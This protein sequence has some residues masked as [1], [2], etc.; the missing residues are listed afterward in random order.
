MIGIAINLFKREELDG[1]PGAVANPRENC[2]PG[3]FGE[4]LTLPSHG[5]V[6]AGRR[7]ISDFCSDGSNQA[8]AAERC[9]FELDPNLSLRR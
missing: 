7:P 1:G 2:D 9:V 4:T 5:I 3:G 8:R 6:R